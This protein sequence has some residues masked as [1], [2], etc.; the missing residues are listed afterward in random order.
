MHAAKEGFPDI[1]QILL[2]SS[3][4]LE[5]QDKDCEYCSTL[6]VHNDSAIVNVYSSIVKVYNLD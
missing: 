5:L 3:A 4:S 1:V 2:D 6:H